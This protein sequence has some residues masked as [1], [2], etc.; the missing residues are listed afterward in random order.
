MRGI[1]R[2]RTDWTTGDTDWMQVR[3]SDRR[4]AGPVAV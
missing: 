2:D 3:L 4:T 1:D